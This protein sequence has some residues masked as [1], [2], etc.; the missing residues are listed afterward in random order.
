M[1]H[2]DL[3]TFALLNIEQGIKKRERHFRIELAHHFISHAQTAGH[4]FFLTLGR[5]S[6]GTT[7][8]ISSLFTDTL[9]DL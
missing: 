2:F 1:T 5:I 9:D 4:S 3:R 6:E 8:N 7:G